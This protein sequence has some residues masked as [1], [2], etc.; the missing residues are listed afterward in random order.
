M[1]FYIS[2]NEEETEREYIQSIFLKHESPLGCWQVVSDNESRLC[3]SSSLTFRF[4][5][6]VDLWLG[7]SGALL[8]KNLSVH[9]VKELL[10]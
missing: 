6:N 10:N 1:G 2:H 3:F 9:L 7:I 8:A 5:G 4:H